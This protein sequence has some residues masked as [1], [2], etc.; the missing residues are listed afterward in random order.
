MS[1]PRRFWAEWAGAYLLC[2][3][4]LAFFQFQTPFLPEED[5]YYHLKFAWLLRHHGLFRS[6]FPW[7]QF[8]LWKD[9]FSDGSI[10]F[11][12]YLIPF[13]FGDLAF[14]GKLATVLL[15]A[16]TASSFFAVLTLNRVRGRLYWFW[17]FALGGGFFWWRMLV[18]RPQ[19]LS[20]A[21]LLWSVH[22]LLNG[23]RK[24]FSA[25][26][27]VYPLSYVA[28]F[29]PQVF[30]VVRWAYLKV[31]EKRDERAITLAGLTAYALATIAHPYFPKNLRFF[32]V[33]NFY[34]MFLAM[35]QKVNLYLAGEF[36]PLDTRQFLG[37]HAVLIAHALGLGFVL[38]HRRAR[39][40]ERTRVTAPIALITVLMTCGSKR[41][42]EYSVPM[43]AL[44]LAFLFE[45]AFAGYGAKDFVRDF[46]APGKAFAL[47]WLIAMGAAT[48]VEASMVRRDFAGVKPPRF[49]E[50]A[51]ALAAAAPPGETVYACDWDET[52]ELL[53]YA[54][55]YRYP[56]I[57]DPTFMYAWNPAI[58]RTWF[59]LSN[60]R[61]TPDE[62]ARDLTG[63]FHARYG[64]CGSK[65]MPLRRML[66]EDRRFKILAE[67]PQGFV[68]ELDRPRG[69]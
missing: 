34:V 66:G 33:Q 67:N 28:A 52:P 4:V 62:T 8:S 27:F 38:M 31:V 24:A 63:V 54:D 14:G 13:T 41:F 45:D 19:V 37:A 65:F 22:F 10:L 44:F 5:G 26:S 3:S 20:A 21:L 58:W 2:A 48:G 35:T 16:F 64:V 15:S 18:P 50:L 51:A 61:L 59:D 60:A 29:L 69:M 36:L 49:R 56:V 17:V 43:T 1:R 11:H 30:S 42:V 7:T 68:F 6:G 9:G 32:F 46:G 23:R 25:L 12:L 47:A 40:S 39:L 55:Q 53:F 57:M